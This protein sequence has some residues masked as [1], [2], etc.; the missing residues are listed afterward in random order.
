MPQ[1][2]VPENKPQRLMS[3]DA[4]RGFI[5]LAMASGGV[6]FTQVV[7]RLQERAVADG[8]AWDGWGKQVWESLAYQFD[9]VA[10]TGC[11]FWD[12][13]QPSFMFMVGVA[14]PFSFSRRVQAGQSPAR[15]FAHVAW[16]A[17]VLIGLGV[18]LSSNGEPLTN[19]TF[20]NVLTQIGLGYA[21]LYLV[22]Q[23]SFR[24]QLT[25]T[26]ADPA[27]GN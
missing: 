16:R 18:F 9:H 25:S 14:M 26:S 10:W 8:V 19:F 1:E 4:Y 2:L 20:V 24:T 6:G 17:L 23:R 15:R 5:M 13:I 27:S 21:F 3:L 11:G 7:K 22:S 12:L